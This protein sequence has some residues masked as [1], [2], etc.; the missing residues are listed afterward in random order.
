MTIK[1]TLN[2]MQKLKSKSTFFCLL[3]KSFSSKILSF[4]LYPPVKKTNNVEIISSSPLQIVL[5]SILFLFVLATP[6]HLHSQNTDVLTTNGTWTVPNC[7][8]TISVQVWGAGGG[9][10]GEG[11][12]GGSSGGGGGGYSASAITVTPGTTYSV[13]IGT[14]GA[15]GSGLNSN[16]S[17]GGNSWFESATT[18]EAN[19]GKGG[20]AGNA[21][22]GAGAGG[23]VGIGTITIAGGN[24]ASVANLNNTGSSGGTAGGTGGGTGGSGGGNNGSGSSGN[25]PG[26]GGGGGGNLG[27]NGGAGANGQVS[28][29][30]NFNPSVIVNT[31]PAICPGQSATLTA[32]QATTYLWASGG[33]TAASIV[34][35]PASTTSYTVTGTSTGCTGI[36]I[37]VVTVYNTAAI[38]VNS[39]S[40]CQGDSPTL[41]SSPA[42]SYLWAPGGE[43]TA[44][45]NVSP[46]STTTYT[47]TGSGCGN[48]SSAVST[49]VVDCPPNPCK[50]AGFENGNFN[51][52]TGTYC[53]PGTNGANN[54]PYP[55]QIN[56]LNIGTPNIPSTPSAGLNNNQYIMSSGFDPVVGGTTLPVVGP[57]GGTYSARLG[58]TLTAGR[59][60]SMEYKFVVTTNNTAFTYNYAVVLS[61]GGH[62]V[63][64]QPY[65]K[66]RMWV[67]TSPTDSSLIPCGTYDVDAN[68]AAS[69]PGFTKINNVTVNN[70]ATTVWYKNWSAVTIPLSAYIGQTVSIQ[71]ITRDC[72]PQCG[73]TGSATAPDGGCTGP[74]GGSH[75]AYGYVDAACSPQTITAA[76]ACTGN[77]TLTAPAGAA[78]YSWKGPGIVSG[79]ATNAATVNATGTYTVNMTSFGTVPC[80]YSLTYTLSVLN[81][82]TIS[83]N[84]VTVCS[85]Q[86]AILVATGNASKYLWAPGGATAATIYVSPASTTVYTV[87]G[88][89]AGGCSNAATGTVTVNPIPVVTVNSPTICTGLTS[90]L[91]AG[92]A[93]SYVWSTGATTAF[94]TDNPISTTSYTVTGNSLGCVSTTTTSINVVLAPVITITPATVCAGST[95]TLTASGAPG[96]YLWSTG[97]SANPIMVMPATT[98]S[99]TVNGVG[100]P[101]TATATVT[102]NP[103]PTVTVT[104]TTICIGQAAT[105]TA[106]GANSY[107]WSNGATTNSI[108]VSPAST[109]S[110][111]V[112]G[113]SLGCTST[114]IGNVT[115]NPLPTPV[116]SPATICNGQ[117]GPGTLIAGGANSYL[118]STG[119]TTIAMTASPTVTT[120]YTVTGNTLGCLNTATGVITVNP[121]PIVTATS[122]TIC[123]GQSAALTAGGASSYTWSTGASTV[124]ITASPTTT[125][126]YTVTGNTLGCINTATGTITVNPIPVVSVA[127][128]T[129]CQG[130]FG[131]L[132]A[133]GANSYLWSSGDVTAG[134]NYAP[135]TTTTYTVI[136]TS[137]GC[138]D[139]V[140][141]IITVNPIPTVTVT[142]TT[143][144]IGQ[145]ATLTA[146]GANS[147]LWSNGATTNSITVSPAS[148]TSY[149]VTGNSLGC[150]ST[151]IG[152]VTVNPLPT[153]VVSPATICNGQGGP[154]TL[155]AGGANSYLWSTGATTIAMTASPTVTTTYTV[156]GN[157]LGCLNTA[158]G[159]ITVNPIPIVTA[160]SATICNGQSAALTAGGA[161]SYTWSTGASTVNITASPTTTSTY[162][163]TGN[164]LGCINTATG[165]ITVNP[166][167]VVSVALSTVCQGVFGTLTASGANSY[168]WSSGDVTAGINYAPATTTTYTVIGTSLGCSDTVIGIITVN[169]LPVVSVASKTICSGQ[170]ATLTANGANSYTWSDGSVTK[171]ITKSPTINTTYTVT[172]NS[173]GCLGTATVNITVNPIPVMSVIS[174]TVCRSYAGTLTAG[175]A[176]SYLW[177]T[178]ATTNT[179]TQSPLSTTSYTVTGTSLGCK[180]TATGKITILIAP[181]VIALPQSVCFGGTTQL[182]AYGAVAY[183]WDNG[184][185]ANP[186]IISPA[187]TTTYT[188]VGL[189][190]PNSSTVT[191]T[192]NPLPSITAS[193]D[194]ICIGTLAKISATD[195]NKLNS[196]SNTNTYVSSYVWSTGIDSIVMTDSPHTTTTYSVVGATA[197]GCKDTA[198][199]TVVVKPNPT[200][201]VTSANACP[202][203]TATIKASGADYYTW[204]TGATTASIT[205]APAATTT[206]SVTGTTKSCPGTGIGTIK[207][208]RFPTAGFLVSPNPTSIF[209]TE[210][211]FT[212]QSSVDVVYWHW[213]YGDGDTLAPNTA[214]PI[215]KYPGQ[216]ATY[217]VTL[218]VHNATPCWDTISSEIF[219]GPEF[220]FYIP[221]SFTPNGDKYNN[222]FRGTGVGIVNYELHI[223]DR[224]G[225]FIWQSTELDEYWD[226]K[227]NGG[228]NIVQ[229]DVYVWKV[230]LTDVF[231]KRHSYIGTVTVVK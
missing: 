107:L 181:T 53:L 180:K 158:T 167:P 92:G 93:N 98:T 211:H 45:I 73:L 127:L 227:A 40:M 70:N 77:A 173:L 202:G 226:G 210:L 151:A 209:D 39:V 38:T 128:S 220:A 143:I 84:A 76:L 148:T 29:T 189:G 145:A 223:F 104:S 1:F 105:L 67:F 115:V 224:W 199:G 230:L 129:V 222:G 225:N 15:A 193:S 140:T 59:A 86:T 36:A 160:T 114:A 231:G 4:F 94:I 165:T 190:C 139:T 103:I 2:L 9:G 21:G 134:I 113:N 155:I 71:F 168:L 85:G 106:N 124:N 8:T 75:F 172:G 25:G 22:A 157:T 191:V 177:S 213:N 51:N 7:V 119:A 216:V 207:I 88:T 57:G 27:N 10:G 175:T 218:I 100:C 147:Y 26:G 16:G 68:N 3:L 152:N 188:V 126:T 116:V 81:G 182:Y 58:N 5:A 204:S 64:A 54:Y 122:A 219:I 24:S 154:G 170:A 28:I 174:D 120:T 125:S 171:S 214:S 192:V 14:G 96:G 183:T 91:T 102:V 31:P 130:V 12:N 137:L 110:Y 141:G 149:T 144:C 163:V 178:G 203:S 186:R 153:P 195:V 142:S 108:T 69:V 56:G 41:T 136:G 205:I 52:W 221:N 131:T 60:E 135:A 176:D 11:L 20:I 217:T 156:T 17:T 118:W 44:S 184:S 179:L 89:S 200:V 206:Y 13:T 33:S 62:P 101:G 66:I 18:V 111:T 43:T 215:H 50:N 121:I 112:T 83:A 159:V 80:A 201:I 212:N 32:T 72:C 208:G 95:A 49:V 97:S 79:A 196:N 74:G 123:N 34:V 48:S 87:T 162:T 35:S 150:T 30:Y 138:S 37:G 228:S 117:G 132:T 194:T 78:T 146:N 47:V 6:L 229:E 161:S 198:I 99:Y 82:V 63:C 166:I 46:N 23:A 197:F 61:D 19:G 133:S 65:F 55:F 90:T 109:T 164:T 169:P 185:T 42:V 187:S